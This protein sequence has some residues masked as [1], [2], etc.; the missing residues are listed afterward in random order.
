MKDR[1]K[2]LRCEYCGKK[3]R[4]TTVKIYCSKNHYDKWLKGE[5][6]AVEGWKKARKKPVVIEFREVEP[7]SPNTMDMG[8]E[9][10]ETRE[11]ILI[12]Y[13]GRDYVIRGVE[14]ELYPISKKIFKKTYEMLKHG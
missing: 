2:N 7:D 9:R 3:L 4:W 5:E 13:K 14:G 1:R 12:A 11:G 6:K 10:I 8:R